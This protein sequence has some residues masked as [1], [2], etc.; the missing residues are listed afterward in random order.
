MDPRRPERNVASP[1][2]DHPR[3]MPQ[4]ATGRQPTANRH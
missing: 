2:S 3:R 4:P 1:V